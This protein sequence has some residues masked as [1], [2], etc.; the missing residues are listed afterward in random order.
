MKHIR[1]HNL[2]AH[3]IVCDIEL[4]PEDLRLI[5]EA[6]KMIDAPDERLTLTLENKEKV[7]LCLMPDTAFPIVRMT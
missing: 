2:Q 5:G 4:T 1:L 7:S 3:S 6:V